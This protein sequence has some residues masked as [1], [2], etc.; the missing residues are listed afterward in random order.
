MMNRKRRKEERGEEGKMKMRRRRGRKE[1]YKRNE[2]LRL[3]RGMTLPY[4]YPF[5]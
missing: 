3:M 4:K 5:N 1:G 2:V